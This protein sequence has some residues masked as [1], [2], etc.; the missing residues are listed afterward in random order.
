[1]YAHHNGTAWTTEVIDATPYYASDTSID[2][3]SSGNP[4]IS[5][6]VY[7]STGSSTTSGTPTTTGRSGFTMT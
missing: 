2:L 3:D 6:A 5:Y 4:H 7:N 1:M